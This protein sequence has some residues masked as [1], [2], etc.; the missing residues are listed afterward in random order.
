MTTQKPEDEPT[1]DHLQE[2]PGVMFFKIPFP[3]GDPKKS[4]VQFVDAA[5]TAIS[6]YFTDGRKR[7]GDEW[8]H[9]EKAWLSAVWG[10]HKFARRLHKMIFLRTLP[11]AEPE[12]LRSDMKDAAVFALFL[13]VT[14]QAMGEKDV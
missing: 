5:L 14:A 8:F 3:E 11:M 7:Y 10:L 12:K 13:L 2:H 4:D 1:L 6:H 9:E